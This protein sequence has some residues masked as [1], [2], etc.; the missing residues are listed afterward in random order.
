VR[1]I[2][3]T[4]AFLSADKKSRKRAETD[5]MPGFALPLTGNRHLSKPVR[6]PLHGNQRLRIKSGDI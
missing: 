3:E 6:K 5:Y 1:C 2:A 4:L